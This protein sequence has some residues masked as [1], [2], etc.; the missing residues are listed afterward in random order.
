[1]LRALRHICCISKPYRCAANWYIGLRLFD[2]AVFAS[3][4]VVKYRSKKFIHINSVLHCTENTENIIKLNPYLKLSAT[5]DKLGKIM[6]ESLLSPPAI[7]R[8]M[9]VLDKKIIPV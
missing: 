4:S 6:D 2:F 8:G 7:V 9:T 1:M 3:H 5:L